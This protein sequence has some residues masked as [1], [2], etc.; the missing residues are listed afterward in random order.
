MLASPNTSNS[1]NWYNINNNG[2]NNNNNTNNNYGVAPE[3]CIRRIPKTMQNGTNITNSDVSYSNKVIDTNNAISFNAIFTYKHLYNSF[4]KCTKGVKWK[5][6]TQAYMLNACCRVARL[7]K[8]LQNGTYKIHALHSFTLKDR[9]K[10]RQ[11]TPLGF[12][13]RIVNKCLCDY[14]LNPLLKKSLIYDCGATIKGRGLSFTKKRLLIHL[15][16]Y[17]RKYGNN[18]YVLK[19]DIHDYFN[20]INQDILMEKL[21]KKIADKRV[22]NLIYELLKTSPKGLGLGSQFSQI[23]AIYYLNDLDHYIK[24]QLRF[25]FYAR[26]MDDMYII[27]NNKQELIRAKTLIVS[28]LKEFDLELSYGKSKIYE[29]KQGFKFCQT[30]YVLTE[31]GKIKR[32]ICSRS[33]K[34]M[35]NKI[36]KGIE[37]NN[38]L[39]SF[40]AYISQFN[41]H[42][43]LY[44]LLRSL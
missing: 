9:G 32:Y 13:N 26:Y 24:E 43:Q 34:S 22:L 31:T 41:A 20:S 17:Y 19:L 10:V 18:G 42:R 30:R 21:S 29:L 12:E 4:E 3:L 6:S 44:T 8:E 40:I 25:K 28:K 14:Y 1:N 36:N 5:S 33:F 7:Y 2:N 15:Q 38:I 23:C 11:I 39:P 16:K 37:I 27:S 35:K